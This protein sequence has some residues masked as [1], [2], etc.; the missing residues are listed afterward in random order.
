M[1]RPGITGL[2]SLYSEDL[3]ELITVYGFKAACYHVARSHNM[4][5]KN[6][7]PPSATPNFYR[8]YFTGQDL[9]VWVVCNDNFLIVAFSKSLENQSQHGFIDL[10]EIGLT[11]ATLGYRVATAKELEQDFLREDWALLNDAE[12]IAIEYWRPQT[13]GQVIFNWFD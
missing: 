4:Q 11:F 1:I 3:T 5:V 10:P 8:A 9:E 13:V 7:E 12:I 6:I 2:Y